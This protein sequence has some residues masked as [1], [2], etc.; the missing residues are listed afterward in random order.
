MIN[1]IVFGGMVTIVPFHCDP[2]KC[3]AFKLREDYKP[4]D[5]KENENKNI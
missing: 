2:S 5:V 4:L 1:V 3:H